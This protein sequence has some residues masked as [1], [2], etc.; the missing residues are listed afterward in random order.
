MPCQ[1]CEDGKWKWGRRGECQ[2]NSKE[3]CEAA[4]QGEHEENMKALD[5][6]N[7]PWAIVPSKLIEIREIYERHVRGE[8]LTDAE[9]EAKIGKKTNQTEDPE[10]PYTI[11]KGVGVISIDGVL[12]KKMNLFHRISGGASTEIIG[13]AISQALEDDEVKSILLRI[14]SPGGSVDGTMELANYIFDARNEKPI[15][16]FTDGMMA[17]GAYWIGSAA[18]KLFISSDTTEVG[19]IGVVATH[20]DISEREKQFGIKTTEI[21]AGK[22]KRIASQFQPLSPEGRATIQE[23]VD[24]LYSVFVQDVANFR[25][26]NQK[27]VREQMAE[28]K[29]FIGRQAIDAGLVDGKTTFDGLINFMSEEFN[30]PME[31]GKMKVTDLKTV[32][33]EQIKENAPDVYN[34]ILNEGVK[35]GEASGQQKFEEGY[36]KGKADET[37]RIQAV[38]GAA[39]PGHDEL[40]QKLKF[41]GKTTGPEAAIQIV[42]AEKKSGANRLNKMINDA[43]N[44]VPNADPGSPSGNGS[45]NETAEQKKLRLV[46]EY[47]KEHN[48][49]LAQ[50]SLAVSKSNPDLFRAA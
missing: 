43:P 45:G 4:H 15:F 26:V 24:Y 47:Q 44:D 6:L 7:A 42:Q 20:I 11:L 8:R 22:Y 5:I 48:C 3:E 39:L 38:E 37:K 27:R 32:T 17:S 41:D 13:N 2:Y 1:E 19:S 36:Q 28:G 35:Q 31:E 46:S 34:Q 30:Q 25:G 29:I 16:A 18:K 10:P 23:M 49:T 9:I 14:D 40:V 21:V 12:A 50:A 33:V